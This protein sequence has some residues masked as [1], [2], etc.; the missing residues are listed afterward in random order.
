M[1]RCK[2][3]RQPPTHTQ[4]RVPF[5]H[6]AELAKLTT[7]YNPIIILFKESNLNHNSCLVLKR[8]NPPQALNIHKT[9]VWSKSDQVF[10][11]SEYGKITQKTVKIG[12]DE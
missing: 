12:A 5:T 3:W 8:L 7:I 10:W 4:E 9:K 1:T 11:A 6:T 2:G